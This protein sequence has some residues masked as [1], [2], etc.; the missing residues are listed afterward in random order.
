MNKIDK[1]MAKMPV[2]SHSGLRLAL[3]AASLISAPAFAGLHINAIY[4][5]N[6]AVYGGQVQ[7]AFNIAAAEFESRFTDN[8]TINIKVKAG[9][10]GLGGSLTYLLGVDDFAGVRSALAADITSADDTTSVASLAGADPTHGGGFLYSRAQARALGLTPAISAAIDGEFTFTNA[11]GMFTFDPNNRAVAGK[12]DFIGVAQH[13]ISEIMGRIPF[14]GEDGYYMPF[15]LFRYTAPGTRDLAGVGDV[16]F[17]IDGGLTLAKK[18]NAGAGG[19]DPQD[20]ASGD[21]SDAFNAFGTKGVK[22][23]MSAVDIQ[24]MDVIGYNLAP[25]PEPS[26]WAMLLAGLGLAGWM[27]RRRR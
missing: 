16:Y 12:Y 1:G 23:G 9:N 11:P 6:V 13:E 7:T 5:P 20:W 25:V 14:L 10:T 26:A 8:I 2:P 18:F 22:A 4:D 17:S 24:T 3:L 19:S 15:D 21:P 27:A